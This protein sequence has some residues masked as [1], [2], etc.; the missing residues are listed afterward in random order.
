MT[1]AD[2]L[3]LYDDFNESACV[4]Y[5]Q[6]YLREKVIIIGI[7]GSSVAVVSL[8]ENVVLLLLLLTSPALYR[9][10]RS[11][12]LL[13][14]L[15]DLVVTL[16]Y[17]LILS[18]ITFADYY[19]ILP[20]FLL[21]HQYFRVVFTLSHVAMSSST[22]ILLTATFERYLAA[23]ISET[24]LYLLGLL[25]RKRKQA[26]LVAVLLGSVVKGSVFFEL[27]IAYREDCE[28]FASVYAEIVGVHPWYDSAWRFWGRRILTVFLPFLMLSYLNASIV[29]SLRRQTRDHTVKTLILYVAVGSRATPDLKRTHVKAATR[30]LVMV[31]S[32]YLIANALDVILASWEYVDAENLADNLPM[33]YAIGSDIASM[34]TVFAAALRLPIYTLNDQRIRLALKQM[35]S[36]SPK[37]A[38]KSNRLS[39]DS[40]NGALST[41]RRP[42]I[43]KR[44]LGA[45]V[46]NFGDADINSNNNDCSCLLEHPE[47]FLSTC[48]H[49]AHEISTYITNEFEVISSW[50]SRV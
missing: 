25:R 27:N 22:Y 49:F 47:P 10:N 2:L 1:A 34:L 13:M 20:L 11:Y 9:N 4:P 41:K 35:F 26:M 30:S 31:V 45:F 17:I 16:S 7:V 43:D 39:I 29:L 19:R 38:V 37:L 50:Q 23:Q 32:C 33:F 24:S 5:F 3:E 28:N 42:T 15:F 18:A 44:S 48:P 12:M 6:P 36:V 14:A 8:I 46:L 40:M 21:W